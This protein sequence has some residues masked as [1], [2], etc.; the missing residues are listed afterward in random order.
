MAEK[1]TVTPWEVA[2]DI[3]YAK[4]IK[5]FG[6]QPLEHMILNMRAGYLSEEGELSGALIGFG[7]NFRG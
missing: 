5:E 6:I 2:G 4:L 3:D 1:F 7:I